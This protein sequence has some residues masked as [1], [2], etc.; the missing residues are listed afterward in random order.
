MNNKKVYQLAFAN[1]LCALGGGAVLGHA[2]KLVTIGGKPVGSIFAFFIGTTLGLILMEM[3]AKYF[4]EKAPCWYSLLTCLCSLL[5]LSLFYFSSSVEL[6]GVLGICALIALSFRFC[7]WF[8]SRIYRSN[9]ASSAP[10]LLPLFEGSYVVGSI[11]GLFIFGIVFK[12]DI[13][14]HGILAFDIVCALIAFGI[15]YPV[16]EQE[17]ADE[18]SGI[19][20]LQS[21]SAFE[22]FRPLAMF[23]LISVGV[24][25][26]L[27]H[28]SKFW[29][30]GLIL[31]VGFYSGMALASVFV[32]KL[33]IESP[34]FFSVLQ[35]RGNS[36]Q[37]SFWVFSLS[38][39]LFG[40]SFYFSNEYLAA[41]SVG[42]FFVSLLFA[43]LYEVFALGLVQN[44]STRSR[45][46]GFVNPVARSYAIMAFSSAIAIASYIALDL[47]LSSVF[48]VSITML[49]LSL[50]INLFEKKRYFF[51]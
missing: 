46:L 12:R 9:V 21:L 47:E 44:I 40:L 29:S 16:L 35:W 37:I 20:L 3:A 30:N 27:F 25:V 28:L 1:F 23:C 10:Q 17:K 15:D 24:Q 6:A 48:V 2:T 38:L 13:G 45:E 19:G 22:I 34:G 32:A 41:N 49:C 33:K 39:I 18:T 11:L 8:L 50:L 31:I 43:F 4:S 5:I 14:I 36:Y 51:K 42:M 7:F 26:C